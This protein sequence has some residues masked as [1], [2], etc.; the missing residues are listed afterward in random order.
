MNQY[1]N[2]DRWEGQPTSKEKDVAENFRSI[3]WTKLR[4]VA[5]QN[6]YDVA[7]LSMQCNQSSGA[8]FPGYWNQMPQ[9][10]ITAPLKPRPGKCGPY[11]ANM[12]PPYYQGY[13]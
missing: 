8:R 12:V 9:T 2:L 7:P 11:P 13:V 5:M 3:E 4:G 10:T 6:L 1:A